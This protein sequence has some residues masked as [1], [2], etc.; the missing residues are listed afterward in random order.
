MQNDDGTWSGITVDLWKEIAPS[1][2]VD[3]EFRKFKKGFMGDLEDRTVDVAATGVSV[4]AD[5][6]KKI[7]FSDSYLSV[8][9]AVAVNAD[10]QPSLLQVLRTTF[11]NWTL[12]TP[13]LL[14][15]GLTMVGA[16]ILWILEQKGDSEHYKG[17]SRKAFGESLFWSTMVLTGRELP[18]STGWTTTP[19]TTLSGRVF[20]VIWML[21]GIM[22]ITL[23]TASIASVLTSKQLQ[24]LIHDPDDLRHVTVGT[25]SESVGYEYLKHRG[26]K[27]QVYPGTKKMLEALAAHKFDAAVFNR[28]MMVYYSRNQYLNKI[29]VLHIP[30]KQDF[31]ALPLQAKSPWK[32]KINEALLDVI[33]TKKWQDIVSNY[34]GNDWANAGSY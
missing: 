5:R 13:I 19:P 23:I 3:Y 10:Q 14:I 15:L 9:E 12:L 26:I 4:T 28:H 33:E 16:A 21:V 27:P 2:G 32:E 31:L 30:L 29:V 18:K 34:L 6:E 25:V 11:V 8:T 20:G 24:G 17:R 22:L 1:I 7:D